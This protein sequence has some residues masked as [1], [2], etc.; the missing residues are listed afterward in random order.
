MKSIKK[1]LKKRIETIDFLLNVPKRFYTIS[2]FHQ[3]HLEIKKLNALIDLIDFCSKD[4]NRKK[5]YKPF[6]RIFHQAGKVRELQV[7]EAMMKKY[8]RIVFLKEY[9]NSLKQ[10][11]IKEQ[12][13]F[14][15]IANKK[16]VVLLKRKY[17]EILPYLSQIEENRVNR[18]MEMRRERIEKLLN[19]NPLPPTK[20]HLLR[21]QIKRFN[22][23]RKYL[24][25]REENCQSSE[26]D[27]LPDLLGKWHDSQ[28]F[29][30][31]LES[32]KDAAGVNPEAVQQ[33]ERIKSN[34][35]SDTDIL[36]YKINKAI[37]K[38]EFFRKQAA[39]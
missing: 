22:Y 8:L 26:W 32:A 16:F 25:T 24:N 28:N 17:S 15:S 13:K 38:S 21:K 35:I 7:E 39:L 20:M 1:Y 2:T 19:Q 31:Y 23:N 36:L 10:Q 34:V 14:F 3:L 12:K 9:N 4:F 11:R 5:I 29:V 33:L 37:P 18:F 6:K 30:E 27:V